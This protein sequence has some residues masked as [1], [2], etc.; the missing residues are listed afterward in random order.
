MPASI[1]GEAFRTLSG[2]C[3]PSVSLMADSHNDHTPGEGHHPAWRRR[4]SWPL[5]GAILGMGFGVLLIAAGGIYLALVL[6]ARN[7][8]GDRA[9]DLPPEAR[10]DW[11]SPPTRRP[12]ATE[13][14]PTRNDTRTDERPAETGVKSPIASPAA[15]DSKDETLSNAE[16]SATEIDFTF[17][18]IY[19]ADLT[20]PK[21]W[22]KPEWAGAGPYGGPGLPSGFEFVS[23]PS[24]RARVGMGSPSRIR[25]PA[26]D[27]NASV[28][29]LTVIQEGDRQRYEQPVQVVGHIP[30]TANPGE[31]GN[32]WY[33]GH[34]ESPR[35]S[36]GNVFRRLPEIRE[37][38]K[39]D[40]VDIIL[41]SPQGEFLYRV[42][43]WEILPKEELRLK[44]SDA[45]VVTLVAS[46]PT[47][48]YDQRLVVTGTLLAQ[49]GFESAG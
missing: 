17:D 9:F 44:G 23:E 19:P 45:P 34:L 22:P 46:F 7:S 10:T 18:A 28:E 41:E 6:V 24:V 2:R 16:P 26:I 8:I 11:V 13:T 43:G 39:H 42:T 48:V 32:G 14:R 47:R 20:N 1:V 15:A 30:E 36:E 3:I 21:Y 12:V 38:V 27:L 35:L 31:W 4:P 33:F 25:I 49:R 29:E 5:L 40:P 37:L